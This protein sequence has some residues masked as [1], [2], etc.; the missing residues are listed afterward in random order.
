RFNGMFALALYNVH[1]RTLLLARDHAGMK[2][3]YYLRAECGVV[4]ASQYD[5]I[6]AHPWSA[7]ET[8]SGAALGLYL[9]LGYVPAPFGLLKRTHQVE[10]GSWLEID[11]A[12]AIRRGRYFEYPVYREPD[13]RGDTANQAVDEALR[14]SV[15]RHLQADVSVGTFLSGGIDSPLITAMVH[16]QASGVPAFTLST[17]GDPHDESPD[18]AA[19]AREIGVEHIVGELTQEAALAMLDDVVT[20]LGEPFADYSIFPTM[21][22]SR[23]ARERVKVALVGDGG[24]ELFFGYVGRFAALLGRLS[25]QADGAPNDSKTEKLRR[26]LSVDGAQ[27][28]SRWPSTVGDLY[29]LSHTQAPEGWLRRIF[30][31]LPPWPEEFTLFRHNDFDADRTAQWMRWNELSG[32]LAM[33]LQKVDRASMFESLE[34]RVPLLDR[35]VID[36]ATRID[37]RSSLNTQRRLGK[38]P[39]RHALAKR[40]RHQTWAKRGFTVAMDEWM[41]GALRPVFEDAVLASTDLGGLELNRSGAVDLLQR[42]LE[43]RA[44]HGWILWMLLS[45]A[46]WER[47]YSRRRGY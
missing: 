43:G 42:H 2:P 7:G 22:V 3:L 30:P 25:P 45:L 35:E 23:L 28:D 19:Y 44:N 36:I 33:L 6:M 32:Y 21:F 12:G 1:K 14:A 17:G 29:R 38:L 9:R 18:A 15:R 20:A 13:L 46:L 37:W 31:N 40:V 11:A 27:T 8:Y 34:A 4:F 5:Q 10:A 39:L 41:R 47:K 16:E 26:L 24:D